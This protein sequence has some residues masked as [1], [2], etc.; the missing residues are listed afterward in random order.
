MFEATNLKN[1]GDRCSW[2]HAVTDHFAKQVLQRLSE[3]GV[4]VTNLIKRAYVEMP[5]VAPNKGSIKALVPQAFTSGAV[6]A[7]LRSNGFE[8]EIVPIQTWKKV[9]VDKGNASKEDVARVARQR[10]PG[11]IRG[12]EKNQDI[13]DAS[14]LLIYGETAKRRS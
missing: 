2:A 9:A 6:Q 5:V 3:N 4:R 8:V 14:G 7:A 11:L 10:W 13:I 12:Y 1:S